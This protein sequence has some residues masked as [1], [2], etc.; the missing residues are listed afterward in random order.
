[1]RRKS[2]LCALLQVITSPSR[3]KTEFYNFFCWKTEGNLPWA[4]SVSN[5]AHSNTTRGSIELKSDPIKKSEQIKVSEYFK[6]LIFCWMCVNLRVPLIKA[7]GVLGCDG[8]EQ[9]AVAAWLEEWASNYGTVRGGL[10]SHTPNE[11][12]SSNPTLYCP[13]PRLRKQL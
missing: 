4:R 10:G 2:G 13:F 7:A 11:S 1:M 8:V 5:S 3:H 6:L 9:V 12:R